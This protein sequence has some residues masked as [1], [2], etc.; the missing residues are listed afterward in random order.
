MYTYDARTSGRLQLFTNNP[1]IAGPGPRE[2][3]DPSVLQGVSINNNVAGRR[4]AYGQQA[5]PRGRV[6]PGRAAPG[7]PQGHAPSRP[8]PSR[9]APSAP[10]E[11][12]ALVLVDV[13]IVRL[14][15]IFIM[16]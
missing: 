9:P 7:R 5:A 1:V 4:P 11:R 6:Q 8:A 14:D 12:S 2:R 13:G 3:V 15:V 10:G 16:V